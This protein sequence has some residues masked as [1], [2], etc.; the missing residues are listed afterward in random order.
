MSGHE[1]LVARFSGCT[2]RAPRACSSRCRSS[3]RTPCSGA[4][5]A[6]TAAPV[7]EP[8]AADLRRALHR[9]AAAVRQR[10]AARTARQPGGGRGAAP[11]R[12]RDAR[13]GAALARPAVGS[14][15]QAAA[16]LSHEHGRR[17]GRAAR[18][19]AARRL[20]RGRSARADRA[21]RAGRAGAHLRA[22][23]VAANPR[24]DPRPH[25]AAGPEPQE[26]SR[27]SS[28]R[29][30]RCGR[31]SRSRRR[32]STASGSATPRRR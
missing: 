15:V 31:A 9:G 23:P 21:Q 28:S 3:R 19:D 20:Q 16:E 2:P 32:S 6:L 24:R 14:G 13:S 26:R 27:R 4:S 29:P 25:A 30:T 5:T 7:I 11:P 22:R 8:H 18:A 12:A 17:L 1:Q 10:S